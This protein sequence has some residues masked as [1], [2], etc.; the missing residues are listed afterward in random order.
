MAGHRTL[1]LNVEN[2]TVSQGAPPQNTPDCTIA[3]DAV[4]LVQSIAAA[5]QIGVHPSLSATGSFAREDMSLRSMAQQQLG[6]PLVP[7]ALH[8]ASPPSLH[9][10]QEKQ[11]M[12]TVC[13]RN[14]IRCRFYLARRKI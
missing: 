4:A 3:R 1:L 7:S 12:R 8:M 13:S 2:T 6:T 5:S 14:S 10:L 9:L 11:N